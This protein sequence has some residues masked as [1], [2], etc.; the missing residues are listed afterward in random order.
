[1]TYDPHVYI[2]INVRDTV[3]PSAHPVYPG[4]VGHG[5]CPVKK[6]KAPVLLTRP[7]P[8]PANLQNEL[9]EFRYPKPTEGVTA[10]SFARTPIFGVCKTEKV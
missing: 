8:L 10:I 6:F 9:P 1:M 3:L 7:T 2:Y 4:Q 5:T